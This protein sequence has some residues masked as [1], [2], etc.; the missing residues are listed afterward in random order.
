MPHGD[1]RT[2]EFRERFGIDPAAFVGL[3]IASA[4]RTADQHGVLLR[5][6]GSGRQ[7]QDLVKR[8]VNVEVDDGRIVRVDGVY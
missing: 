5:V 1:V 8:R 3:D 6:L 7:L 2:E 4:Q